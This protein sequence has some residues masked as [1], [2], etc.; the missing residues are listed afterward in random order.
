LKRNILPFIEK[1]ADLGKNVADFVKVNRIIV[2]NTLPF[3]PSAHVNTLLW[4]WIK[5]KESGGN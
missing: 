3:P 4:K 2:P 5:G 1:L